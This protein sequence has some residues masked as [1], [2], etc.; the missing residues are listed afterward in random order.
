MKYFK[1]LRTR[2]KVTAI[3]LAAVIAL[4]FAVVVAL[5]VSGVGV[6]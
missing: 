4:V 6:T 3:G 1:K 5:N 2:H